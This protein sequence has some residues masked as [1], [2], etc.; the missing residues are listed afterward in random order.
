ME[1]GDYVVIGHNAMVH[2]PGKIGNNVLIGIQSVILNGAIIEDN[3]IIAAGAVL[4]EETHCESGTLWAGV[5]AKLVKKFDDIDKLGQ[6][7]KMGAEYYIQNGK[8][9]KKYFDSIQK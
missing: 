7:I 6:K 9:F 8:R 1:I 2:G 4:K 3:V 5:P